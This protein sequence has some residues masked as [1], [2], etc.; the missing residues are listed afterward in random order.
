MIRIWINNEWQEFKELK[1]V[2][3]K[4]A[5]DD[6][7]DTATAIFYADFKEPIAKNTYVE[8]Y[9]GIIMI[10]YNDQSIPISKYKNDMNRL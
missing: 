7:L 5:I 2:P 10:V 4:T 9:N 1:G 6:S 8:I 3:Y